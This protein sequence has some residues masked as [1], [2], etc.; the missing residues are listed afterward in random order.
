MGLRY[1]KSIEM[2][3]LK[4]MR[5]T[6]LECVPYEE[7]WKGLLTGNSGNVLMKFWEHKQLLFFVL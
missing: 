3:I 2:K 1:L 5:A 4:V 7:F 6:I